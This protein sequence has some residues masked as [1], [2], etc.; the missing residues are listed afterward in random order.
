MA[1]Q[2][3]CSPLQHRGQGDGFEQHLDGHIERVIAIYPAAY[4][5]PERG[6]VLYEELLSRIFDFKSIFDRQIAVFL[7]CFRYSFP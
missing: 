3:E 1:E 7:L 6:K 2:G 4:A 5:F